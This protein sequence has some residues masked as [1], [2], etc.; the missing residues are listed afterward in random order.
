MS[1]PRSSRLHVVI[2][3][4]GR[5]T[6]MNSARPKVLH[7]VL[8]TP[9]IVRVLKTAI[10]LNPQKITVVVGFGSEQVRE[11]VNTWWENEVSVRLAQDSANAQ[12]G[13][14]SMAPLP[15]LDFALQNPPAGTGH[16]V[17]VALGECLSTDSQTAVGQLS[18]TTSQG[19]TPDKRLAA[20]PDGALR[21]DSPRVLVMYGDV[22]ALT[23]DDLEP[24]L[25]MHAKS[26]NH[27]CA[28]LGMIKPDPTGYGRLMT[29]AAGGVTAIV[30]ERDASPEQKQVNFVNTG[31][32]VAHRH[33]LRSALA[34]IMATPPE[35]AAKEW[36]LTDVVRLFA[37]DSGVPV[38]TLAKSWHAEGVND[39]A[40][41][42]NLERRMMDEHIDQWQR[43]GLALD[44][45]SRVTVEGDLMFGR[46]CRL[47]P[48]VVIRGTV[49]LGSG[50]T[51]GQ[52][53]H[54]ENTTIGDDV[55]VLAYSILTSAVVGNHAQIGPHARLRPG[56]R[57]G[58]GARI[59]NFVEIKN[60]NIGDRSKVNHLSYVGDATVGADCNLGAGTI[61][62]NYDGRAKYRTTIGDRA[63][64]GSNTALVA[65]VS[66]GSG[67]VIGAGSVITENVPADA[68]AVARSRQVTKAQWTANRPP[69]K[70]ES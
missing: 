44:A 45:P 59:G 18:I 16:A 67:S 7:P 39:Q 66:V 8:G 65:P 37:G 63:F 53:V 22:P 41:R 10:E 69:I 20:A 52:G 51:I 24:L 3:A 5:G 26:V 36:Y 46:D 50:V 15:T 61:T 47:G 60:A 68:L 32:L 56:S 38:A 55:T 54:L 2:L 31:I 21:H 33:D 34:T 35:N 13:V 12:R 48:D 57:I 1:D 6:R 27:P 70:A 29:N 19:I 17:A 40:Q 4:A 62:C 14:G 11:G 9:M 49:R 23:K 58:T 43:D 42:S 64:I 30:E 25:E 28:I